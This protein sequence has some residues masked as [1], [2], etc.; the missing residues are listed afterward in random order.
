MKPWLCGVALVGM[1][2]LSFLSMGA[3]AKTPFIA[4]EPFRP[5]TGEE[6]IVRGTEPFWAVT[7]SRRGIVYTA[8]D[9]KPQSFPYVAPIA[10][11]GRPLDLV[12]VYR[13]QGPAN[14]LLIIKKEKACS[15]GMSDRQYPYSATLVLGNTV[16]EGC[17]EKQL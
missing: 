16:R 12:R 10:A 9:T 5:S 11:Q 3:T 15:D 13:L 14:H 7:V 2:S 1:A 8:P 4:K 17:A 6:F